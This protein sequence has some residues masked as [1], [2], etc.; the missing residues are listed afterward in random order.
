MGPEASGLLHHVMVN[1]L[2]DM[3]RWIN[4]V[5][6]AIFDTVPYWVATSDFNEPGQPLYF[7]QSKDGKSIYLF[8]LE[9]P[10]N[11]RLIVH[12]TLPLH[13]QSKIS[14]MTKNQEEYLDW[15]LDSNQRLVVDVLDHVLDLERIIW[16]FKIEAP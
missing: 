11:Q 9:R 12:A 15:R 1:T 13:S 10:Q 14:L 16:V 5:H 2:L 4:K 7:L 3:G 8:S 6:E